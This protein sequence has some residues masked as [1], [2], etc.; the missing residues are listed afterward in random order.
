MTCYKVPVLE[1]PEPV[2]ENDAVLVASRDLRL[3]ASKTCWVVQEAM[4]AKVV[5]AFADEGITVIRGHEYDPERGHGFIWNQR[6]GMDVFKGI[7]PDAKIIV[8]EAVWQYSH[9]V[10]AGLWEHRGPSSPSRT[11]AGS[12]QGS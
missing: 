9:H 12:G 2:E 8:A 11:G 1:T 4:E 7:H 10:L 5:K 3:S 6:M